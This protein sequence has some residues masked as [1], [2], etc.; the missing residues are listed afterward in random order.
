MKAADLDFDSS[1][2][3]GLCPENPCKWHVFHAQLKPHDFLTLV[4]ASSPR[5]DLPLYHFAI[6][7][8]AQDSGAGQ[9]DGVKS[10]F[11]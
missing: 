2:L 7:L 5:I 1:P 11:D 10:S 9:E 3:R 4:N 6:P 8:A